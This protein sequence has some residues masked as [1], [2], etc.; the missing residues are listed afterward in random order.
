M[1]RSWPSSSR[2]WSGIS[3]RVPRTRLSHSLT[4][5]T[6]PGNSSR[7]TWPYST[8]PS[9]SPSLYLTPGMTKRRPKKSSYCSQ[10]RTWSEGTAWNT[11]SKTCVLVRAVAS[12]RSQNSRVIGSATSRSPREPQS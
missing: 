10:L 9:V 8:R 11:L 5:R 4:S 3:T 2:K 1:A 7:T 12:Q 6:P